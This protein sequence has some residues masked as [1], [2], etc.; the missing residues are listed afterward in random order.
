MLSAMIG[1]NAIAGRGI[2][3]FLP[4]VLSVNIAAM[5]AGLKNV[6]LI[7]IVAMKAVLQSALSINI[8]AMINADL[9]REV[10]HFSV[11]EKIEAKF[12]DKS[13]NKI[14][15]NLENLRQFLSEVLF[16]SVS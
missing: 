14:F 5:K 11:D 10:N 9:V 7:S 13:N 16:Y 12:K 15:N 1:E 4:G 2:G 6:L 3:D 8:K